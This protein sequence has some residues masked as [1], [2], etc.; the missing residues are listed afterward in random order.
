M[1]IVEI[2]REQFEELLRRGSLRETVPFTVE[3][4]VR[5]ATREPRALLLDDAIY[6]SVFAALESGKHVILTGPPGTAK[7]TLAE[8]VAD[9]AAEAGSVR[10]TCSRPRQRTGRPTR[11]SAV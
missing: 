7:T 4:I 3:S 5:A 1:S 10:G 8:A 9:A 2:T 6:A 11:R